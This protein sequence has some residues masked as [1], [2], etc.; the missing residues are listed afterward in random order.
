LRYSIVLAANASSW[1]DR[2][3]GV[4]HRRTTRFGV[5]PAPLGDRLITEVDRVT[6]DAH[7]LALAEPVEQ[8]FAEVVEQR[9]AGLDQHLRAEVG[10]AP[11]D[12]RLRVEHGRH[13]GRDQRVGRHP[14]EVDVVDHRDLA[15]TQATDEALGPPI[16]SHKATDDTRL[17]GRVRR[18]VWKT[19]HH[20]PG[21]DLRRKLGATWSRSVRR[22]AGHVAHHSPLA[23]LGVVWVL[24]RLCPA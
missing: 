20:H 21:M 17:A 9:D 22:Q 10:V 13:P 11:G 24:S 7:R 6:V 12:R 4:G 3:R 2:L 23:A 5:L 16:K 1:T 15:R 19:H 14:V 18:K 8:L